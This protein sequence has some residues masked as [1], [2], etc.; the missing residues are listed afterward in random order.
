MRSHAP[1]H[2]Q[3]QRRQGK[4]GHKRAREL[5]EGR[6]GKRWM[7]IKSEARKF[8][9][10]KKIMRRTGITNWNVTCWSSNDPLFTST[11]LFGIRVAQ[12]YQVLVLVQNLDALS[13]PH[14]LLRIQGKGER[15]NTDLTFPITILFR[16]SVKGVED[17]AVLIVFENDS[18]ALAVPNQGAVG[19]QLKAVGPFHQEQVSI[20][21]VGDV[22]ESGCS[23]VSG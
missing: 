8:P 21:Q 3:Y 23:R 9:L 14:L 16:L 6:K 4:G 20:L 1:T 18:P 11:M 10:A 2:T 5:H 19:G 15:P 22:D 12:H 7:A 17:G 13:G